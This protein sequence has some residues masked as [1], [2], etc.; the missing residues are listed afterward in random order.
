MP[1]YIN[2]PVSAAGCTG[3]VRKPASIRK[4]DVYKKITSEQNISAVTSNPTTCI[5]QV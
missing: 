4:E 2:C 1:F 3:I 5:H